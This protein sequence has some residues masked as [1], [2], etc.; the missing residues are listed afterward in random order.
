MNNAVRAL[1][2]IAADAHDD[3][4][5]HLQDLE[6]N[7][8]AGNSLE[9]HADTVLALRESCNLFD[10]MRKMCNGLKELTEKICCAIAIKDG[11]IDPIRTDHCTATV[12]I[13]QMA[14]LPR[15]STNPKDYEALMSYLCVPKSL[16]DGTNDAIRPHWPGMVDH[17]TQLAKEGKPLPPGISIDKV[18]PVYKLSPLTKKKGILET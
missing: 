16:W 13:K 11:Q 8:R 15:R 4:Y 1:Y 9:E 17:I 5:R 10:D 3:I 6:I 2:T 14:S 18:Y 7:V 12:C